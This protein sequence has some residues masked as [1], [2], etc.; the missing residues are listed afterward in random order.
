MKNSNFNLIVPAT[1]WLTT[2]HKPKQARKFK[3]NNSNKNNKINQ[4]NL[5]NLVNLSSKSSKLL[6]N[7]RKA[8]LE[9]LS[10]KE[11]TSGKMLKS[12]LCLKDIKSTNINCCMATMPGFCLQLPSYY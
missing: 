10:G 6:D 3:Y 9:R 2:L 7:Q 12:V 8:K 5:V 1:S 11:R 4:V